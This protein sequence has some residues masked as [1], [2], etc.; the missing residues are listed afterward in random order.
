MVFV[1]ALTLA[2]FA[3][4]S[5]C[6]GARGSRVR[7]THAH[8]AAEA[9]IGS[10]PKNGEHE[11]DLRPPAFAH[12]V[13]RR[14]NQ[15]EESVKPTS[16]DEIRSAVRQIF[17][18]RPEASAGSFDGYSDGQDN[19]ARKALEMV[20]SFLQVHNVPLAEEVDLEPL[21]QYV[22]TLTV[23]L[24]SDKD[25]ASLTC[26]DSK[27]YT[28]MV[29]MWWLETLIARGESSEEI[30]AYVECNRHP[31]QYASCRL[32]EDLETKCGYSDLVS[33]RA[34]LLRTHRNVVALS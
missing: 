19:G 30:T 9:S 27:F 26:T 8:D 5:C 22:L 23:L 25:A 15:D 11:R 1:K 34:L 18:Y 12:A 10:S 14:P 28:F 29:S 24:R 21:L 33:E 20:R 16:E 2:L 32:L 4:L 13:A 7:L 6:R 3:W 31:E 17:E